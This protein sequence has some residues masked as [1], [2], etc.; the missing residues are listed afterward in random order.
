[1]KLLLATNVAYWPS[2][3]G[4]EMVLQRILEGVRPGFDRVAVFVPGAAPG[5]HNG[6]EIFPY[7]LPALWR[8]ALRHR[9]DVYFPNMVHSPLTYRNL[10]VVSRLA[11]RTVVNLIGGYAADAPLALRRRLLRKVEKYADLAIHVDPLGAEYLIDRAVNPHVPYHF[12]TQGL[13]FAELDPYRGRAGAGAEKYFVFAHNLWTWKGVDVFL[14]E[15]VARLPR[16]SFAIL[17]SDRTGDRIDQ[18]REAAARYPNLKLLLGLPRPQFLA[19]LS[20][21]SGIIST[22]RVEGAQPNILLESGYL[23]VPYLSLCPGQNYGH[24]PH[25][26]MYPSAAELARRVESAG[27]E[28]PAEKQESLARALAHF[29]QDRYRWSTVIREYEKLFQADSSNE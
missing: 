3:G 2:V 6:I 19:A 16:L 7:S 14:E 24:Y 15:I 27:V 8:F 18:T 10:A 25:V 5:E 12:I 20:Q 17:A 1:M 4:S 28:L 22:S 13:D 26:E 21:A 29:A 9:P 11:R 23:G